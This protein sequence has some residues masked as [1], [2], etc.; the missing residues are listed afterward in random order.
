M[1]DYKKKSNKKT[2]M[3]KRKKNPLIL[4]NKKVDNV[5]LNC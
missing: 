2:C 3:R 4:L 1:K 5:K